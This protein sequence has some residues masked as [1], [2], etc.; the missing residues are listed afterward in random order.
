MS[1]RNDSEIVYGVHAA[2]HALEADAKAVRLLWLHDDGRPR[3]V[4]RAILELA[5]RQGVTVRRVERRR[6]D[7][8]S[9][10]GR[11]QGVA[12]LRR[13]P[14]MAS[15]RDLQA[16]LAIE[17]PQRLLLAV[18]GIQD[19]HNLGACMRAADAAGADGIVVPRHRSAPLTP[20][21]RKVACGAAERLPLFCVPNLRQ[22]LER[23]RETGLWL[24]GLDADAPTAI[25]DL[26]LCRP[27]VVAVGSE[28]TGLRRLTRL[29]CD[30]LARIPLRGSVESLNVGVAAGIAL[31]EAVR[32]RRAQEGK[33]SEPGP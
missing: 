5:G 33:A 28:G 18:D 26:D 7:R 21:A 24:L 13:R 19:P 3:Q 29:C 22:A 32:Q 25:Y 2:R 31:F 8:L 10:G 17:R 9:R 6:L 16:L 30:R 12:L 1:G 20:A 15:P 14:P 11:H 23:L 27:L 4:L